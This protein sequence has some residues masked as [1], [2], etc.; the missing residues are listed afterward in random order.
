[1]CRNMTGKKER[2]KLLILFHNMIDEKNKYYSFAYE[3]FPR[4]C[5]YWYQIH[6]VLSCK[7]KTVLE[8][9]VGNKIVAQYL[10]NTGLSVATLDVEDSLKPDITASATNMP[11]Q[12]NTYDA[13]LVAEVLEHLP[14][15]DFEKAM[16]EINRVSKDY[17]V[18]S[19]PHYGSVIA[20]MFKIPLIKWLRFVLKF[21]SFKKHT[22]QENG[23]YWEIG[24]KGYPLS[25]V[26]KSMR[27]AGFIVMR[28]Y[29]IVEYPYHHFFVLKKK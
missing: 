10:K 22:M 20:G 26:K 7:P 27:N 5:S 19:L 2:K 8:I 21:P 24:K 29:N 14:F 15:E 25:R 13:V 4:W 17:A 12:D 1:M 9:G 28:D 18:I 16:S 11:V 3:P 6:E 23:H